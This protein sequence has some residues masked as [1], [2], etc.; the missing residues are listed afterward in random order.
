MEICLFGPYN[1]FIFLAEC[2][3]LGWK[4]FLC[5]ILQ[6]CFQSSPFPTHTHIFFCFSKNLLFQLL[7]LHIL[8][9]LLYWFPFLSLLLSFLKVFFF[10]LYL[11]NHLLCLSLMLFYIFGRWRDTQY[12][13]LVSWDWKMRQATPYNQWISLL[14]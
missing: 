13:G 10:K 12:T 14:L 6:T 2:R 1:N 7:I 3:I 8:N 5:R 11:P 4:S 9:S